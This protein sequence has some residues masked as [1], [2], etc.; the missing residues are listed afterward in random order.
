MKSLKIIPFLFLIL[1]GCTNRTEKAAIELAKKNKYQDSIANIISDKITSSKNMLLRD[2]NEKTNSNIT[3]DGEIC[4]KMNLAELITS[5]FD[6]LNQTRKENIFILFRKAY[7]QIIEEYNSSSS[8]KYSELQDF[9]N[10]THIE[11][12]QVMEK[13]FNKE[14]ARK[15]AILSWSEGS[16]YIDEKPDYLYNIFKSRISNEMTEYLRISSKEIKEGFLNDGGLTI[17]FENLYERIITWENFINKYPEFLLKKEVEDNY[18]KY[19]STFFSGS[20]NTPIYEYEPAKLLPEIKKIYE[21]IIAKNESRKSTKEVTAFYNKLKKNNFIRLEENNQNLPET[22]NTPTLTI[23]NSLV[24]INFFAEKKDGKLVSSSNNIVSEKKSNDIIFFLK[25]YTVP[26]GKTWTYKG[27][28]INGK[29]KSVEFR[30]TAAP[31]NLF[32]NGNMISCFLGSDGDV[33]NYKDH[34][35]FGGTGRLILEE[36]DGTQ[37]NLDLINSETGVI[38]GK[39]LFNE[40]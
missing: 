4:G 14:L 37:L 22:N 25:T 11:Y 30:I 6:S 32:I 5:Q 16:C 15:G 17:S 24:T 23:E 9:S 38:S 34:K 19:L 7:K 3:K 39:L 21:K 40:K 10:H 33:R 36:G 26:R 12:E 18:S 1:I 28:E 35:L 8:I 20:D 27:C 31:A 29:D 13:E 2:D